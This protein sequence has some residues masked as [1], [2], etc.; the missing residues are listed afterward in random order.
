MAAANRFL[1][2]VCLPAHN[3]RS[4]RSARPAALPKSAFVA[5]DPE[6]DI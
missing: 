1:R 6:P 4:I 3:I 2:E 5:A